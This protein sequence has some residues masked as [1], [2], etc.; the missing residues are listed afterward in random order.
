MRFTLLA[1]PLLAC[2]PVWLGD[3]ASGPGESPTESAT[4]ADGGAAL[5]DAAVAA[6]STPVAQVVVVASLDCGHCFD[7]A[8]Q[9]SGG[10]A[11]Y[12]FTWEDGSG[13]AQRRVC[14]GTD[15][16][17][18][19][20]LSAEDARGATSQEVSL[21]LRGAETGCPAP[22]QEVL[23]C[24]R[25]PSLEGKPAINTGYPEAFDAPPWST[26][27]EPSGNNNP[28]IA[29]ET[30]ETS[31]AP[32]VKATD[33][34]TYV[35][36]GE[37]FQV[38]QT[39][40]EPMRAHQPLYLQ[41]DLARVD[42]SPTGAAQTERVFLEIWGGISADC[43][44]RELLWASP[45][46]EVGWKRFCAAFEPGQYLDQLTLRGSSDESQ[47]GPSYLLVDHLVPVASCL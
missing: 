20:S 34:S 5:G 23:L 11:P 2:G 25:N 15:G 35:A 1:L 6:P 21:Q 29:N 19:L 26:C 46:L 13:Q 4:L 18:E 27:I 45:V 7:V 32:S 44:R 22:A 17:L 37:R 16:T 12:L 36:L 39:L 42:L 14:A 3:L 8:A 38:S 9:A 31:V 10:D 47:F 30:I 24:L 41:L 28:A 33:G 40:C 43:S